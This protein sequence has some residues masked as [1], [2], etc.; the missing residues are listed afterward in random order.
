MLKYHHSICIN[1]RIII[2]FLFLC[3][4]VNC[5]A[6]CHIKGHVTNE[7]KIGVS[8]ATVRLLNTDSVFVKGTVTD[9]VGQYQLKDIPEGEYIAAY[10]SIGYQSSYVSVS[11]TEHPVCAVS[12]VLQAENVLL[13]EVEVR[14]SSFIRQK[15]RVLVLPNKQQIKH[16]GTG[17]DLLY[18]LMIPGI[19][20]DRKSGK[21]SAPNGEV[22]LYIDGRKVDFREVQSLRPRD[23]EKVEYFDAPTG[24]YSGDVASINYITRSYKSGGYVAIDGSQTVGYMEGD[25]NIVAKLSHRRTDYTFFAGYNRQDL[26]D[27]KQQSLEKI[28]FPD[29]YV[30][31]ENATADTRTK[32]DTQYAQLNMQN[33]TDKRTLL[34]KISLVHS[35]RPDNYAH[36]SLQY[37]GKY[38]NR[39]NTFQSSKEEGLKPAL[40]LYGNFRI[41]SNQYLETSLTGSYSDNSYRYAYAENDNHIA[42]STDED[43]YELS[44]HVNYGIQLK[45]QDA[46]NAK[47]YHYHKVSSATYNNI[48]WQHLWTGETMLFAEYSRRFNKS[49]VRISPGISSMQYKLHGSE[50]ISQISPRLR[51]VMTNQPSPRQFIQLELNVG[52]SFPTISM[53]NNV[54]QA[55]DFLQVKRGNPDLETT[56]VYMST[57]VYALQLGRVNVQAVGIYQFFQ[58]MYVS[59]YFTE[60]DKLVQSFRT[61]VN[62]HQAMG[63]LS[64]AWKPTDHLQLKADG[65][66]LFSKFYRGVSESLNSWSGGVQANYYWKDFAFNLYGRTTNKQLGLDMMKAYLPATYGASASWSKNGWRIEAGTNNPFSQNVRMKYQL[67][68]RVYRVHG[69]MYPVKDQASAYFK[70]AYTFDFGRQTA[71]DSKDVDMNINSGILKAK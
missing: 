42:T 59:D 66:Y 6:Q 21:V 71:R 65:T 53:L 68:N 40:N 2:V 37:G 51:F 63:M 5:I 30:T 47:L 32:S 28:L 46:L 19:D 57:A 60:S 13:G 38:N 61:D 1:M 3:T 52:N 33:R 69:S 55:T 50:R 17:Y 62:H 15:D 4:S 70:L 44:A 10:S 31:R 7:D 49:S 64:V 11:L 43:L 25:Y 36:N 45:H 20:V 8:Y 29:Y 48:L 9:S 23:I 22:A 58:D 27:E 67:D 41:G 12:V 35:N 16:S 54:E 39:L 56:K 34:A 18:N 14:G 26:K 24:K